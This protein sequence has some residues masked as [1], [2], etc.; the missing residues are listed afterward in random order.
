VL[1]GQVATA[2]RP[3]PE[4]EGVLSF[5]GEQTLS[6]A[7][8][9]RVSE[10]PRTRSTRVSAAEVI[11]SKFVSRTSLGL[12]DSDQTPH[13]RIHRGPDQTLHLGCTFLK[14]RCNLPQRASLRPPVGRHK[15]E[16]LTT[17]TRITG[18]LPRMSI[19]IRKIQNLTVAQ[20][21]AV[22]GRHGESALPCRLDSAASSLSFRAPR[23][24]ECHR[25]LRHSGSPRREKSRSG[26]SLR[27]NCRRKQHQGATPQTAH[28]N[29]VNRRFFDYNTIFR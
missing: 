4:P 9:P 14:P 11:I 15:R 23:C 25:C 20:H 8:A 5:G 12:Q 19:R 27:I 28:P 26:F 22:S 21:S 24:P 3:E 7:P 29:E 6:P 18:R 2:P 1:R 16:H 10:L 17:E 13:H